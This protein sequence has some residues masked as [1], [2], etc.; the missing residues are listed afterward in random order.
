MKQV[1]KIYICYILH[2]FLLSKFNIY[3]LFTKYS[4][5]AVYI[6]PNL[7][8][9]IWYVGINNYYRPNEKCIS[10]NMPLNRSL[11]RIYKEN[12]NTYFRQTKQ[13]F[14]KCKIIRNFGISKL[15]QYKKTSTLW[16]YNLLPWLLFPQTRYCS[17]SSSAVTYCPELSSDTPL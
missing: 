9:V 7:L 11:I 1:S 3:I 8:K 13:T 5:V 6:F 17:K 10:R 4:L 15:H 16:H 14:K 2:S 12:T